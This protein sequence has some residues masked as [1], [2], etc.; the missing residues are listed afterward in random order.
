MSEKETNEEVDEL[1][2][3]RIQMEVPEAVEDRLRGRL[4]EFRAQLGQRRPNRWRVWAMAAAFTAVLAVGLLLLPR[5]ASAAR[6]Y[7]AAAS[8]LHTARSIDFTI[9]MN[10]EPYVGCEFSEAPPTFKRFACSWASRAGPTFR[11]TGN[12]SSC[13]LCGPTSS[14]RTNR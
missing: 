10:D 4:S 5:P 7:A 12:S 8:Q 14:N 11:R 3:S 13:T 6:V 1:M 9:V 2:R